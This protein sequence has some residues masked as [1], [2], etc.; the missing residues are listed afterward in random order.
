MEFVPLLFGGIF[1]IVIGKLLVGRLRHGSWTGSFLNGRIERTAGEIEI[2]GGL[3]SSQVLKVHAM[4]AGANELD[5]V[6]IVLVSKA[7]MA[8]SMQPIKLTKAQAS[9]LAAYLQDAA[10]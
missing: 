10:R 7:P 8:A 3:I 4:K 9:D 1:V 6:A 2:K 5:F